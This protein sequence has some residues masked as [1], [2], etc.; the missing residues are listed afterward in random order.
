MAG[1]VILGAT[2]LVTSVAPSPA[3]ASAPATAQG[4]PYL[5][6]YYTQGNLIGS[7]DIDKA[8]LDK[9]TGALG[10]G[11]GQSAYA[12]VSAADY[13]GDGAITVTDVAGMAQRMIYDD[14]P[15]D[16]V[17]ASALDMQKAMNAGVTSS[18]AI[19]QDYLNRIAAYDHT[20]AGGTDH[21]LNSILA[22]AP[23]ALAE[24]ATSDARRAA[25]QSRGM[26]D[27]I[28]VVLKDNYD[29]TD[30]PTTAGCECLADNQPANDAFMVTGLRDA[31][32]II[33]GKA[34]LDE[35]ATGFSSEYSVGTRQADGTMGPSIKVYSP[36][37]L[38]R[39][40]G[41]SSGGT[42]ASI[43]ANL[44]GIGFG[45]DTGGSIR[46]P[47]SYNQL[48]G[49]R[50]TVGL[51]SRDGIVPLALTQDSGGP[52]ARSVSDAAIALD[53]V[54]GMDPNDPVTAGQQGKVPVS[55]TSYLDPHA[56]QGAR[57]GYLPSL[58]GTNPVVKRLF[59]QSVADLQAQGAT[60][61]D[62][63]ADPDEPTVVSDIAAI[64]SISSGSTDEF[65]TDL[66]EYLAA[67]AGPGVTD[68]SLDDIVRDNLV[69][70]DYSSQ[71]RTRDNITDAQYQAWLTQ[72][73]ADIASSLQKMTT[74][75]D[76]GHLDALIYPTA[77]Q[78]TTQGNNL[79]L[80]PNTGMPAITLPMGQSDPALD[81]SAAVAGAGVNLEMLGRKYD[82][83]QLIGLA[84]SYEQATHHRTTPPLYPALPGT[85]AATSPVATGPATTGGVT[86]TA[87]TA[88]AEKGATVTVTVKAKAASDL[89]AYDLAIGYD[90]KVL[91]YVPGSAG[92]DV[93]GATYDQTKPG[94]VSVIHTKLGSSPPASG[95]VDLAT[96]TF[97]AVGAGTTAVSLPSLVTVDAADK[98]TTTTGLGST[99]VEVLADWNA[100][101]V[102]DNGDRVWYQNSVWQSQWWTQNQKPG[103][104]YGPWMQMTTTPD[105]TA[106]WTPSR[107][108]NTGDK[109]VYQG[110]TYIAQWWTR[111][112]APGDPYGP[113]KKAT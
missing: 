13:D 112:Q 28:P 51:T 89:Y 22:T 17:E 76:A 36:Y 44:A 69:S 78:Y 38:T 4:Y 67:H 40:A 88:H 43:S 107:V 30:M 95:E 101:T 87:S 85:D 84:Y 102:Y 99:P 34:S 46:D 41:G 56:L 106:L 24:A 98:P 48:V 52:I 111:N 75:L 26:L 60:V 16:L 83:G 8:D 20:A 5:A 96:L 62:L 66:N 93:S 57:L 35:F 94:Q 80:S 97:K 53:A 58:V 7:P 74:D 110:V 77:G 65:K 113:W 54:T 37:N 23:Q 72:H 14:G 104:P 86:V 70:P 64:G 47:S 21:G 32:A 27:G 2:V 100:P 9:L 12:A 18:V 79:R 71:Y 109:A 33:L 82:E 55:Y 31:G 63:S 3:V 6:P 15:F 108:F 29:T 59:T 19:T 49:I 45:T 68:R 39:T 81:G 105:G 91:A 10:A 73:T 103:D 1:A 90:P 42:G 25:G 61:I 92:T 11:R 50:P